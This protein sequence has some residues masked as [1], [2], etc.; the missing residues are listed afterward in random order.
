MRENNAF[1]NSISSNIDYSLIHLCE[2]NSGQYGY[3][4]LLL[5]KMKYCHQ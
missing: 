3:F 2:R 1:Q 5:I 4:I